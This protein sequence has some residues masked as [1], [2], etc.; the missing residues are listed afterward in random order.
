MKR[1]RSVAETRPWTPFE[2]VSDTTSSPWRQGDGWDRVYINSRYQVMIRRIGG[3]S[4]RPL[5]FDAHTGDRGP[6]PADAPRGWWLS[7]KTRDKAPVHDWRDFQ[8][9]KN[10]LIGPE[11]EGVELY[12]AESRL[13]DTSNQYH[14]WVFDPPFRFPFGY[15][16][17][18]IVKESGNGA[19]Q[20]PFEEPPPD[21]LD[22]KQAKDV[23]R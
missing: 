4:E 7:I 5:T 18:F 19:V 10:E 1:K 11:A 16:D 9:I 15:M 20:R 13:V 2:D 22:A 23:L 8:R 6:I 21:A 17:R 3:K 14:L 12:P